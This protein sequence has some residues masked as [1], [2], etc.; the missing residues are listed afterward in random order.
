[1]SLLLSSIQCF[2]SSEN[3]DIGASAIITDIH[4]NF[5]P[6]QN[7]NLYKNPSAVE[8]LLDYIYTAN[9]SRNDDPF[10]NS[11]Q[12]ISQLSLIL[13]VLYPNSDNWPLFFNTSVWLLDRVNSAQ[14]YWALMVVTSEKFSDTI[15]VP[16]AVEVFPQLFMPKRSVL[17][18][19]GLLGNVSLEEFSFPTQYWNSDPGL[20]EFHTHWHIENPFWWNETVYGVIRHRKGELFL[21]MH[22]QMV[23]RYN[24]ELLSNGIAEV[25]GLELESDYQFP[26][27]YTPDIV[28]IN[29]NNFPARRKGERFRD[30]EQ[31]NSLSRLKTWFDRLHQGI[32]QGYFEGPTNNTIS[33]REDNG[34]DILGSTVESSSVHSAN[35]EYYGS[36]HNF[37]HRELGGMSRVPARTPGVEAHSETAMRDPVFYRLHK[38]VDSLFLQIKSHAPAYT[39]VKY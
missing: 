33:L 7:L 10:T 34:T 20:N 2:P 13:Y 26:E 36:F 19:A 12:H 39:K 16:S 32:E 38:K 24:A 28:N 8:N 15:T 17:D 1:M 5:D 27:P 9:I 14:L 35:V 4:Q 21:Y 30:L 37:L 29:Y 3:G 22:H 31:G 18:A 6:E 25:T 11:P 23:C